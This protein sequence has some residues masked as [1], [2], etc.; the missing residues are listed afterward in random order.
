MRHR[1]ALLAFLLAFLLAACDKAAASPCDFS[2]RAPPDGGGAHCLAIVG[3]KCLDGSS[4]SYRA[5]PTEPGPTNC[6]EACCA[7][8]GSAP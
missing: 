6:E 4:A 8:G 5:C 1:L 7:H 3:C 2:N